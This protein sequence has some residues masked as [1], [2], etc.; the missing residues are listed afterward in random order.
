MENIIRDYF[1]RATEQDGEL[2][3][4]ATPGVSSCQ[5]CF[6][7][8]FYDGNPVRYDC[9]TKRL[10]YILRYLPAHVAENRR[11]LKAISR[12]FGKLIDH[13]FE[14]GRVRVLSL[15]GGPGSDIYATLEMLNAW[16]S[17]WDKAGYDS[18]KIKFEITRVDVE[19]AWDEIAEDVVNRGIGKLNVNFTTVHED[20]GE[21][22]DTLSDAEFDIV[23]M[24]YLA[25][26]LSDKACQKLSDTLA[27]IMSNK[28][29]LIINDRPQ[30]EVLARIK[31]IY[32]RLGMQLYTGELTEIHAGFH[33]PDEI[34]NKMNPSPKFRMGSTIHL[35]I[36]E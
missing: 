9:E 17:T 21:G 25:S 8:M 35:G 4:K 32:R 7:Q 24:S 18:D 31:G 5:G 26:E 33:Y 22:L 16:A 13:W 36:A 12:N 20:V 3:A 1:T 19:A 2:C 10:L 34:A 14:S 27:N 29:V 23:T 15:G 11:G 6:Q 30:E 28:G